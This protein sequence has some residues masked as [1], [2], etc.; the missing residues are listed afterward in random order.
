[1][2]TKNILLNVIAILG[3]TISSIGQVNTWQQ[4][5][6]FPVEGRGGHMAFSIGNFGYWAGGDDGTTT[7]KDLW[8]YNPT[9]DSWIQKSDMPTARTKGVSFTLN[10]LGYV[11]LGSDN[12]LF[13]YKPGTNEWMEKA[14]FPGT[15][16]EGYVSFVIGNSAYVGLGTDRSGFGLSDIWEYNGVTN[17]W[18][19]KSDFIGGVRMSASSFSI[20]GKGY[21]G[22][23]VKQWNTP[24]ANDFYEYD[25]QNDTWTQ[26]GDFPAAA[27]YVAFSFSTASFGYIGGGETFDPKTIL[28]DMY[29]YN[30]TADSWTQK[31]NYGGNGV[32]YPKC[33]VINGIAYVGG[34]GYGWRRDLWAYNPSICTEFITVT[35]TLVIHAN[36]TGYNPIQYANTIKIY[37]NP[38]ADMVTI[39]CGDYSNMIGYKMKIFNSSGQMT[40][41]SNINR[42]RYYLDLNIWGGKGLYFFHLID[43]NGETIDIKKIVLQ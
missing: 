37:P 5:A 4:M 10:G 28:S 23:G 18:T 43:G 20:N 36:I 19:K 2:K 40:F 31:A 25:P 6:N 39:D 32:V 8:Q 15:W 16:R 3:F 11:C 7:Y 21:V 30:P 42:Q 35:D 12:S 29:E 41:E 1:M 24:Y 34:G 17:V 14:P 13:A 22:L 9:T 26:K 38:T 33:F 27:R